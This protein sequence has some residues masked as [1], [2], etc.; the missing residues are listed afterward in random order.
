MP[1]GAGPWPRPSVCVSARSAVWRV[2]RLKPFGFPVVILDPEQVS[3]WGTGS[4]CCFLLLSARRLP[5]AAGPPQP[6]G[7]A[8]PGRGHEGDHFR[9]SAAPD[10]RAGPGDRRCLGVGHTRACFHASWAQGKGTRRAQSAAWHHVLQMESLWPSWVGVPGLYSVD[11]GPKL[12][13]QPFW[14]RIRKPGCFPTISRDADL[15]DGR[16]PW[17]FCRKSKWED[18]VGFSRRPGRSPPSGQRDVPSQRR[19]GRSPHVLVGLVGG[20]GVGTSL[21]SARPSEHRDPGDTGCHGRV[22]QGL[23]Q[24]KRPLLWARG[25]EVTAGSECDLCHCGLCTSRQRAD[26]QTENRQTELWRLLLL[27]RAPAAGPHATSVTSLEAPSPDAVVSPTACGCLH[28]CASPSPR[29]PAQGLP[30]FRTFL[31]N[32]GSRCW[33]GVLGQTD[34]W[35]VPSRWCAEGMRA[36]GGNKKLRPSARGR[37]VL[38]RDRAGAGARRFQRVGSYARDAAAQLG[39]GTGTDGTGRDEQPPPCVLPPDPCA[40]LAGDTGAETGTRA[41]VLSPGAGLHVPTVSPACLEAFCFRGAA[42]PP[43]LQHPCPR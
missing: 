33:A 6:P 24:H 10:R 41:S 17:C 26:R 39:D 43:P 7:P 14:T 13:P 42:L 29:P 36:F 8:V 30:G 19:R 11:P 12:L 34:R 21:P 5:G 23:E 35:G 28:L 25:L 4:A 1:S 15:S 3:V 2:A 38:S 16:D 37:Q 18:E 32:P 20:V 22:P 40:C 31:P 9:A 27:G